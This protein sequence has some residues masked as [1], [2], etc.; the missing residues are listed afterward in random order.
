MQKSQSPRNPN[1]AKDDAVSWRAPN[2]LDKISYK[3]YM[4]AYRISAILLFSDKF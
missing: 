1:A 4:C 2:G 3:F